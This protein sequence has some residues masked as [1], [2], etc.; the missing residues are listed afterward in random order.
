MNKQ[1]RRNFLYNFSLAGFAFS[2]FGASLKGLAIPHNYQYNFA[3]VPFNDCVSDKPFI[4]DIHCHPNLKNYLLGKKMYRNFWN[5]NAKGTNRYNMQVDIHN[6]RKGNVRGMIASHYLPEYGMVTNANANRKLLPFIRSFLPLLAEKTENGDESNYRQLTYMMDEFEAHIKKTNEKK[7]G[8]EIKI[9]KTYVEFEAIVTDG[10]YIAV[11]QSVEG[12]HA[13]GRRLALNEYLERLDF[14]AD[15]GICMITLSHFFPNDAAYMA[16]GIE[17]HEKR[18]LKLNW[19]YDPRYDDRHLT[20]I[21]KGI[22][23]HM[24]QRGIVI[25]LTHMSPNGRKDVFEIHKSFVKEFGINR[26]LTFSHGGFQKVYDRYKPN[27]IPGDRKDVSNYKYKSPNEEEVLY[28]KQTD[29]VVGVMGENFWLTGNDNN[30]SY[31]NK[32]DFENGIDYIIETIGELYLVTGSYQYIALGS[33]FDGFA[34][35]PADFRNPKYFKNLVDR[36]KVAFPDCDINAI[37]HCN[38][39]RVLKNGWT[40]S[41]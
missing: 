8:H 3:T 5:L 40:N 20:A 41:I 26:P 29:G 38:A 39:M 13:L 2:S 15:R 35:A 11:V 32:E 10:R 27:P 24:L 18:K 37:T 28:I 31:T 4:V 25:D 33:D 22:I 34:N 12:F 16:E 6:L 19:E 14:L 1:S 23:R 17:P 36:I 30:T 21:G 9:A 7:G